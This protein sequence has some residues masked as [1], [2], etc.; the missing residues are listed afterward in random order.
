MKASFMETSAELINFFSR[1]CVV[2][3]DGSMGGERRL[4]GK[5]VKILSQKKII[6][7]S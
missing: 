2:A 1:F 7:E 6:L 3:L 4:D 5:N